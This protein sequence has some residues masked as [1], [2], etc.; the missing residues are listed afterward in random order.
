MIRRLRVVLDDSE[1]PYQTST[2]QLYLL[3]QNAYTDI[4]IKSTQWKFFHQRGK[5]FKS[6]LTKED[7]VVPD[8]RYIVPNSVYAIEDGTTQR[9][10]LCVKDYAD[11]STEQASGVDYQ[12]TPLFLIRLPNFSYKLEPLPT[13]VWTV[14]ADSWLTY[15]Q[16]TD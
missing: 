6:S 1:A 13:T 3:I 5:L 10:P 11:W 16:F 14:Y 7:Y 8:V 9:V 2:D 15:Q 12:G 4:Q